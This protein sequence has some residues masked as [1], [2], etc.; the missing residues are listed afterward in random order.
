V[1]EVC[2]T[3]CKAEPPVVAAQRLATAASSAGV[4]WPAQSVELLKAT[5]FSARTR[6]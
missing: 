5:S 6:A 2:G 4:T 1:R 3:W